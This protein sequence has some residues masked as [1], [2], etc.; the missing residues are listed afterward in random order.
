VLP[1]CIIGVSSSLITSTWPNA[2]L[3]VEACGTHSHH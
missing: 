3:A 1:A 2:R